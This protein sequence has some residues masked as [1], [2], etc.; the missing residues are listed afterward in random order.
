[1]EIKIISAQNISNS[2][3]STREFGSFLLKS[4]SIIHMIHWYVLNYNAHKILGNLYEDLDE[5]FD[6]LQEEIIGT[7]RNNN[8]NF[9]K[10]NFQIPVL[11]LDD[12]SRFVDDN[13]QLLDIYFEV[14]K[15]ITAVLTSIEFNNFVTQV[16]S[17]INNTVEEILSRLNKANYLLS[18][19]R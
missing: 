7:T 11:E 5:L 4:N 8:V 16:K 6:T 18:L 3:D 2:L 12:V 14:F 19:V 15:E 13:G 1:M 17:G 9:P 10:I